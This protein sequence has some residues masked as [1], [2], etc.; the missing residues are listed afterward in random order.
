MTLIA[1]NRCD[2]SQ[3]I[4]DIAT[5]SFPI[6]TKSTLVQNVTNTSL[7]SMTIT[8]MPT[9]NQIGSQV[10]CALASDRFVI[11][12]LEIDYTRSYKYNFS[13]NVQSDQ[14]CVT[15]FIGLNSAP[16]CPGATAP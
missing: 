3:A 10:F 15:L 8:W 1:I 11:D 13:A 7:W 16:I 5:L 6:L 2:I 9:A 12:R 4:I 14:Y